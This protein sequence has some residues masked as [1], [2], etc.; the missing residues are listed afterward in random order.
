MNLHGR[1]SFDDHKGGGV[2]HDGV[3]G[4][5]RLHLMFVGCVDCTIDCGWS[6]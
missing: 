5:K 1:L 4:A 2:F 3:E 6:V